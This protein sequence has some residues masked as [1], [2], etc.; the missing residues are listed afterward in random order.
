MDGKILQW[1]SEIKFQTGKDQDQ[2]LDPDLD[3]MHQKQP[4]IEKDLSQEHIIE[5]GQEQDQHQDQN[6]K[7]IHINPVVITEDHL[8]HLMQD[9]KDQGQYQKGNILITARDDQGQ[10]VESPG[11]SQEV[12]VEVQCLETETH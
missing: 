7:K 2:N 10:E 9:M 12:N 6:T 11:R 1:I 3:T 8:L 4:Q 5:H